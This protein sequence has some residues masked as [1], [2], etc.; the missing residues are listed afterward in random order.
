VLEKSNEARMYVT[1]LAGVFRSVRFGI[2]E[3]HGR[4]MA[5]QFNYLLDAGGI[6]FDSSKGVPRRS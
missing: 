1:Y 6:V 5:F 3:S 2:N 4:G